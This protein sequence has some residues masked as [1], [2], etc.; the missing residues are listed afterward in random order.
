VKGVLYVIILTRSVCFRWPFC[1]GLHARPK[2]VNSFL[3]DGIRKAQARRRRAG[4]DGI[5]SRWLP[6]TESLRARQ[7][8]ERS[9]LQWRVP[10][11]LHASVMSKANYSGGYPQG[12]TPMLW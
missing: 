3:W 6:V 8:Y 1:Y 2:V 5:I 7:C 11:G 10:A 9:E 4:V 12:C